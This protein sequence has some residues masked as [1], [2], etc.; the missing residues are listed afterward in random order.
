MTAFELTEQESLLVARGLAGELTMREKLDEFIANMKNYPAAEVQ[1]EETYWAGIYARKITIKK[2]TS[3]EGEIH[4]TEHMN[5]IVSGDISVATEFGAER[6]T[7]HRVLLSKPGSKRI[8]Y[9]HEDTVWITL[10]AVAP[11]DLGNLKEK[12]IATGYADPR[13]EALKEQLWLG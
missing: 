6:I 11:Q 1:L 9:A 3:L 5:I 10:H 7:G 8:G 4:L 2:G 13:L 12:L